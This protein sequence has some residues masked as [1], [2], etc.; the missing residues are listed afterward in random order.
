MEILILIG[1]ILVII[2][3]LR[4]SY[5]QSKQFLLIQNFIDQN[6]GLEKLNFETIDHTDSQI[7]VWLK[8]VKS[9][10]D[11]DKLEYLEA[12][13]ERFPG[14]KKFVD[15]IFTELAPYAFNSENLL[16]RR[17]ALMRL[18]KHAEIYHKYCSIDQ[19][20]NA[21]DIKNKVFEGIQ[22][23]SLSIDEVKKERID[24]SLSELE[25]IVTQLTKDPKN[26]SLLTQIE[27]IDQEIDQDYLKEY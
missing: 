9:Q 8:T 25:E 12:A 17:E 4:E 27:M 26:E 10:T 11:T 13:L 3:H 2:L 15:M 7:D 1:V 24:N 6:K 20:Q 21:I 14:N 5:L 22:S 18:K 23:I 16:V 19:I